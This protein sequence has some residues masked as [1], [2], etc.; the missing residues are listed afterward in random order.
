MIRACHMHRG[1][2]QGMTHA[3][4]VGGGISD[5]YTWRSEE[6]GGEEGG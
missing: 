4:G 5:L 2:D 3:W 1:H 6:G